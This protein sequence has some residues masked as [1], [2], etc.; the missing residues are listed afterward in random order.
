MYNKVEFETELTGA[1][2]T[3]DTGEDRLAQ[4]ERRLSVPVLDLASVGNT[5]HSLV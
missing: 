2:G 1:L 3:G 4:V 5:L